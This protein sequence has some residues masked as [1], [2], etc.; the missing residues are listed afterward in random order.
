MEKVHIGYD[1]PSQEYVFIE[2]YY[3]EDG[4]AVKT[5][6]NCPNDNWSYNMDFLTEDE[7]DTLIDR[8]EPYHLK[9]AIYLENLGGEVLSY[10]EFF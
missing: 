3:D 2:R 7:F 1:V 10:F 5:V 4:D 8:D 9:E 6:L